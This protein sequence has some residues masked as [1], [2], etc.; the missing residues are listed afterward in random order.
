MPTA[1]RSAQARDWTCTTAVTMPDPPGNSWPNDFIYF[2]FNFFL[3]FTATPLAHGS[4]WAGGQT[5]DAALAHITAT[6]WIC[7]ASAT[8]IKAYGNTGSL[9]HWAGPGIKPASSQRQCWV[10][11]LLSHHGNSSNVINFN[12]AI[13]LIFWNVSYFL[14][15]NQ[16][17]YILVKLNTHVKF[18]TQYGHLKFELRLKVQLVLVQRDDAHTLMTTV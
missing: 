13:L 17:C 9:T 18:H 16:F 8:Y 3:F 2:I 15:H 4:S 6:T 14:P 12:H 7:A 11:S 5:G 1:C 10:L